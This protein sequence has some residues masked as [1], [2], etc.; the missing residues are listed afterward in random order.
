MNI[1]HHA[2]FPTFITETQCDLYHYIRDD[3]IDWIYEYQSKTKS[4]ILS[5]RGGWQSPS[6]FHEQESFL[7][8]KKYIM[9][10]VFQ[11]LTHYNIQ[12][13]LCNMW[14]NINKKNNYNIA[15]I[16]PG[17]NLSGVFW[18]KTSTNCGNLIFDNPHA[19]LQYKLIKS[20][21]KQEKIKY[22]YHPLLKFTPK[23]GTLVLFPAHLLHYVESNE[24]DEDRIS[25]AF[26]LQ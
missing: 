25:I 13:E 23:E 21:D 8:F 22:N 19:F 20:I 9:N 7:D 15:H 18:I 1:F 24:S 6:D 10:N 11:S 2:V 16:H 12:F 3:L 4:V 17:A 26:N 14:V 5:N